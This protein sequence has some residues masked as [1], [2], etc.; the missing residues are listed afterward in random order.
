LGWMNPATT[1]QA[2]D[3][4]ELVGLNHKHF[5]FC[6]VENGEMQTHRGVLKH[7][8]MIGKPWGSQIRSHTGSPFVLMPPS[9][10]NL[11][12][13]MRRNTQILYP[14]DIGYILIMLGIGPGKHVIEAGTGSGALT[15]ALAY[16]VGSEGKVF[17]YE[18]RE[19][20]QNLAANNLKRLG[21]NQRVELKLRD[22]AEGFD[23]TN[24]DALFLDV[25]NPYDYIPQVRKALKPGGFFG[26]I[27]PTF[28]QLELLL[29]ALKREK[30]AF[31]DV[32]EILMRYYKPQPSRIRPADRMVAHT[33]FLIFARPILPDDS[34]VEE[35]LLSEISD[36]EDSNSL[37]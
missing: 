35:E 3:L 2:G 33:G 23:E 14:K 5:T 26:S 18:A 9:L 1:A 7:N 30:F 21:L 22:I 27:L 19:Q 16:E 29:N 13:D 20:M 28:N 17:S 6:L 15:S 32:C 34:G 8:D 12:R 10:A 37:G 36:T 31:I 25:P 4:V 11:L 24:V